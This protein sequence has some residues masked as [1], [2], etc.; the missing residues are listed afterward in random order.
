MNFKILLFSLL[1][2]SSAISAQDTFRPGHFGHEDADR[3]LFNRIGFPEIKGDVTVNLLCFTQ[4]ETSGKMKGT[5]CLIENEFDSSFAGAVGAAAKKARM[6]PAE[7]NGKKVKTYVQFRTQFVAKGDD[8]TVKVIL[9]TGYPENVEAYGEEHV[10]AQRL[11]GKKEPWQDICPQR[12]RYALLAKAFVGEDGKPD[13]PSIEHS[14]GVNP[15]PNCQ[16]AI[17]ESIL[18]SRYIPAMQEGVPVP[19][20]FVELF[21]N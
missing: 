13:S 11:I 4:L 19:S 16:N 20:T 15:T 17:M 18:A 3:Q 6:T 21:T 12:A 8:R 7:I 2:A 5:S 10:A 1:F 9:N 14:G